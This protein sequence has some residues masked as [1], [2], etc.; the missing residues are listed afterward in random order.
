[1]KTG[2]TCNRWREAIRAWIGEG[3]AGEETAQF[4]DHLATCHECRRYA[5]DL[6]AAT[7]GLR[8][9]ADQPV[10]PSSG[11]RA[12]WTR[13]VE[14]AARP[15]S[16]GETVTALLDRWRELLMHN[17]RP[18]LGVSSLWV[19]ALLFRLSAPDVSPATPD[20][21]ARSPV[22]IARALKAD[23][24]L[25][26]WHFWR[27]DPLP[28]PPRPPQP[29]RPRSERFPAQPAAQSDPPPDASATVE[30]MFPN[31]IAHT[32]SPAPRPVWTT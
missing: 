7:A 9:L 4:Q 29:P 20:T 26:A 30:T 27:L 11:F 3:V 5:E 14:E 15:T 28:S 1:M 19:L 6:R 12:R 18:A 32:K 10:E 24:R 31:L 13:A 2:Q 8:W 22:E 25:L 21:A 23:Q 16:A 17:R